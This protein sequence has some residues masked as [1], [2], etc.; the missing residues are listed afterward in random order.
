MPEARHQRRGEQ[1]RRDLQS[2][3]QQQLRCAGRVNSG[4]RRP[5]AV[6]VSGTARSQQQEGVQSHHGEGGDGHLVERAHPAVP[7]NVDSARNADSGQADHKNA[8][9]GVVVSR[10]R[11]PEMHGA[12]DRCQRRTEA[13]M[14]DG[15]A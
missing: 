6:G 12:G 13:G 3:D 1:R 11:E 9:P 8:Q 7:P 5:A 4:R 10:S 15:P 14:E 2:D